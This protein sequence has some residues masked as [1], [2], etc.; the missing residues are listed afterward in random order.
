MLIRD[1][2]FKRRTSDRSEKCASSRG[3]E[4]ELKSASIE[5]LETTRANLEENVAELETKK[6]E[7]EKEI[8]HLQGEKEKLDK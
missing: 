1:K 7:M 3:A 2:Y 5:Q 8:E 6:A 4:L